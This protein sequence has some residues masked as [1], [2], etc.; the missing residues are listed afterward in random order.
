MIEYGAEVAAGFRTPPAVFR[1]LIAK[2]N[3]TTKGVCGSRRSRGLPAAIRIAVGQVE[4]RNRADTS[5][6][7]AA[8]WSSMTQDA[9]TEGSGGVS[10]AR[11]RAWTFA[12]DTRE[13]MADEWHPFEH[14]DS[15]RA[16]RLE[17]SGTDLDPRSDRPE[18]APV[19]R[20]TRSD[21]W[22]GWRPPS[23]RV[24]PVPPATTMLLAAHRQTLGLRNP[25]LTCRSSGSREHRARCSVCQCPTDDGCTERR[26]QPS[27]PWDAEP[28]TNGLAARCRST[29]SSCR[30]R[31]WPGSRGRWT[32]R[33]WCTRP[34]L[35]WSG[36]LS[37]PPRRPALPDRC[38]P[39]GRCRRAAPL[40]RARRGLRAASV[41]RFVNELPGL[42]GS[43]LR[44]VIHRFRS[45]GVI[46][47]PAVAGAVQTP[48]GPRGRQPAAFGPAMAPQPPLCAAAPS[49]RACLSGEPSGRWSQVRIGTSRQTPGASARPLLTM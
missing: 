24:R 44:E 14:G 33:S 27:K 1:G 29:R 31:S 47:L 7:P 49:H 35:G 34:A 41:C 30:R 16:A 19:R 13:G 4:Q 12:A 28:I 9:V 10:P 48:A 46:A 32:A 22:R 20:A 15:N 17:I 36:Q 40:V 38:D 3:M 37:R 6:R 8:A 18:S 2:A 25:L 21:H 5:S 43:T 45:C 11:R 39:A 42:G 23:A 26:W